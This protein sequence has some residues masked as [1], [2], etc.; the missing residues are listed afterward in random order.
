MLWWLVPHIDLCLHLWLFSY[1]RLLVSLS[2]RVWTF[3]RLWIGIVKLPSWKA[4]LSYTPYKGSEHILRWVSETSTWL[5]SAL[6]PRFSC[7]SF[8]FLSPSENN[9]KSLLSEIFVYLSSVVKNP[10]AN[11]RDS[12]EVGSIPGLGRSSREGNGNPLKYSCLENSVARG[13]QQAGY[14][15]W[16]PK[17]SDTTLSNWAHKHGKISVYLP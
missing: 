6:P 10:P 7:L 15:P 17:E 16:G 3:L 5:L 13:T 9:K 2:Q 4:G 8:L 14:S 11:A 1:D 12:R